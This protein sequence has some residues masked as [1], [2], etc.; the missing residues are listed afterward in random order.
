MCY[1]STL[2][3]AELI[4]QMYFALCFYFFFLR[5][6]DDQCIRATDKS[7]FHHT[8]SSFFGFWRR[9]VTDPCP[10]QHSNEIVQK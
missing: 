3:G 2:E 4:K 6:L 8:A 9:F 1:R 10:N 7:F 5:A